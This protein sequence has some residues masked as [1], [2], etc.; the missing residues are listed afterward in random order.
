MI[1]TNVLSSCSV[2]TLL[3][4]LNVSVVSALLCWLFYFFLL[5]VLPNLQL[6]P[7]F[8]CTMAVQH[9]YVQFQ[10]LNQFAKTWFL[11]CQPATWHV[12]C[13]EHS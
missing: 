6:S 1:I 12:M 13:E 9:V 10:T 5:Y 3:S 4:Y 2:V 11:S 8:Q 7:Q